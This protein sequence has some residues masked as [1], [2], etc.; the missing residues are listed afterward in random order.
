M[1]IIKYQVLLIFILIMLIIH[2]Q[3]VV[4]LQQIIY[5]GGF[6]LFCPGKVRSK[7]QLYRQTSGRQR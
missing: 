5:L 7:I 1:M 2:D 6:L 3:I 4:S